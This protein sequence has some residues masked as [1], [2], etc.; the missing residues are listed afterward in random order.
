MRRQQKTGVA[1]AVVAALAAV[2]WG[3]FSWHSGRQLEQAYHEGVASLRAALGPDTIVADDYQRGLFTSHATLALQ[4]TP[5]APPADEAEEADGGAA[6]PTAAAPAA[7][8]PVRLVIRSDM[9]HGPLAGGRIAAAAVDTRFALEGLDAQVQAVLAKAASPRLTAVRHLGGS[10]DIRMVVP[11]GEISANGTTLRWQEM[12]HETTLGSDQRQIS[13]R[14]AWPE[15]VVSGLPDGDAE[16]EE[17]ADDSDEV[18]GA[19]LDDDLQQTPGQVPAQRR[20]T[21]AV[22]G[23]EGTFDSRMVP[24]LWGMGPG[25]LEMRMGEVQ[26]FREPAQGQPATPL[27][28]VKNLKVRTEMTSDDA[29]LGVD[30]RMDMVGSLGSIRFDAIQ[31]HEQYQRLDIE[32][33]RSVL[34]ELTAAYFELVQAPEG[35]AS[36][37]E[38]RTGALL[39]ALPR[40]IAARPSYQMRMQA[41]LAGQTGELA[42]GAQVEQ[43][44]PAGQM[45]GGGWLPALMQGGAFDASVRLPKAWIRPMM[46]MRGEPVD[47]E[48]VEA[49]LASAQSLGLLQ[50][51]GDQLTATMALQSGR[52]TLNGK[53]FQGPLGLG[54]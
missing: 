47:E 40:L 2:A 15:W 5:P 28:D 38:Q 8:L 35:S 29:T 21:V 30:T 12:V 50:E 19:D 54:D 14:F 17:P 37:Y 7:P 32:A 45:E 43:A 51:Q 23:M 46:E 6:V 33:L 26:A 34:R 49:A 25:H 13:G 9:R 31:V 16:D 20:S 27:V 44:P 10:S 3:G 4:W 18:D 24:G 22:R 39:E 48:A 52:W 1:V 42:Y 11:A 41:T 53:P 36:G